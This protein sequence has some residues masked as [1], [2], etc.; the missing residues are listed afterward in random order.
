MRCSSQLPRVRTSWPRPRLPAVVLLGSGAEQRWRLA[1]LAGAFDV[2]PESA[3]EETVL[4]AVCRAL[5]YSSGRLPL[6]PSLPEVSA[7][8]GAARSRPTRDRRV[9]PTPDELESA[10]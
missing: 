3:P 7:T 5:S 4:R 1:I 10:A 8:R 6:E 2:L 9:P